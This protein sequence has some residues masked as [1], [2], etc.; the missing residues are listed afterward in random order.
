MI[1][2]G[3]MR[4]LVHEA[5]HENGVL[6]DVNPAPEARRHMRVAHGV[7]HRQVGDGVL[8]GM[9]AAGPET[10]EHVRI[11][12]VLF[13]RFGTNRGQDGLTRQADFQPGEIA[14]R[15]EPAGELGLHDGVVLAVQHVLLARPQQFD[16]RA[17][18]LLGNQ[19]R[20]GDIVG[21][22]APAKTT[23]KM[24]LVHIALGNRQAGSLGGGSQGSLAI[25][26]RAPYFATI[27]GVQRGGVVRLHRRVVLVGIGVNSLDF[28]D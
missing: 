16:R 3:R 27:R 21:H 7:I 11:L 15:I 12:A 26:R 14:A 17:R 1:L 9:L 18:H 20:L 13:Q 24:Q 8:K 2:S 6:V 19:H 5:F 10:L 22:A 25:L 23:A 4:Q 28:F